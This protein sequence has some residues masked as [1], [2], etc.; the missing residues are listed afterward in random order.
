[1]GVKLTWVSD[2]AC[3]IIFVFFNMCQS[4]NGGYVVGVGHGRS[5]C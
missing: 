2:I 3:Q 1:M 4:V 5:S